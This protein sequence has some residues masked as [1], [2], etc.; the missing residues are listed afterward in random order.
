MP[1]LAKP[2]TK[3]NGPE[4]NAILNA[5]PIVAFLNISLYSIKSL[6]SVDIS[7]SLPGRIG[8]PVQPSQHVL[9]HD[10]PHQRVSI[11]A[12]ADV[13]RPNHPHDDQANPFNIVEG[14]PSPFRVSG[15]SGESSAHWLV[16]AHDCICERI[17]DASFVYPC[18]L[19][20]TSLSISR[21]SSASPLCLT[22][23]LR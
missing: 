1:P 17:P 18:G 4:S 23:F 10:T 7:R 22:S 3:Y 2:A 13:F 14:A 11:V 21:C 5:I 8:T 16:F 15:S 9:H 6:N 12:S 19:P 20:S